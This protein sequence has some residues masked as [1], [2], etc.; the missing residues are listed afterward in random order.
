[1]QN[2]Q[3]M[4]ISIW[5]FLS[6]YDLHIAFPTL[7]L[8]VLNISRFTSLAQQKGKIYLNVYIILALLDPKWRSFREKLT[9]S[10]ININ[11]INV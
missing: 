8:I 5:Q 4:Q 9:T 6:S 1:M 7:N 11:I 10:I 3:N 2:A